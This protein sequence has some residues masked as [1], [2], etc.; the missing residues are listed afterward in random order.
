M[1]GISVQQVSAGLPHLRQDAFHFFEIELTRIAVGSHRDERHSRFNQLSGKADLVFKQSRSR[2]GKYGGSSFL[3]K[4]LGYL[5]PVL[6]IGQLLLILDRLIKIHLAACR[7]L[8]KK[9]RAHFQKFLL[10]QPLISQLG[11]HLY[12]PFPVSRFPVSQL[13]ALQRG[14]GNGKRELSK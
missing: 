11:F 10:I 14:T 4:L 13:K 2:P 3:M 6:R 5:V 1:I 7:P 12:L 9:R 8:G